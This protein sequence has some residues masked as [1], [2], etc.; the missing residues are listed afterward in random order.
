MYLGKTTHQVC[1]VDALV[2]IRGG[3][4]GSLFTLLNNQSPTR[5]T[6]ST[7]PN[8]AFQELH[9]DPCQFNTY[10][11]RINATTSAKCAGISDIHLKALGRWKSDAYIKYVRLLLQYL[12][13]LSNSLTSR[14]VN[15]SKLP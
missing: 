2:A 10:S 8:K 14:A 9:I 3:A 5:A 15:L 4:P 7:A 6:F 13:S 12:A 11:I 1:P